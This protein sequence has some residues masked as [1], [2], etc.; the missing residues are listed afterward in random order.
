MQALEDANNEK[1]LNFF[2][3]SPNKK[4]PIAKSSTMLIGIKLKVR[5]SRAIGVI[6]I[7]SDKAIGQKVAMLGEGCYSSISSHND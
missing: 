3:T 6:L 5:I 1:P 7:P 2:W 4:S